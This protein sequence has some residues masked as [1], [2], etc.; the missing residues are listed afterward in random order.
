M[1]WQVPFVDYPSQYFAMETEITD[2]I[3]TVLSRGD[4]MLR[5]QLRD[6]EQNLA[7]FVGTRYSIGTST[8]TDAIHLSLR[9]ANIGDGDEVIT[10]AHT[11]VATGAAIHHTGATPVLVD[12]DDDHNINIDRVRDAITTKTRAI[13]P[14]H[15]NG[16]LC[17]MP[18][19]MA[20]AEKHHLVVIEDSAQALGGSFHGTRGGA[21]GLAGCFSFYPAKMLGAY[22][23][24]GAVTT[25][26]LTFATKLRSLRDH[27]RL[28]SGDIAGW[29]FN[30]RLDNLQA[31]IL[32]LKLR[33]LPAWIERRRELAS[34]YHEHLST[35]KELRLP[36]PPTT[37]GPHFDVFQNY[38][39]EAER[40][41]DLVAYLQNHGIELLI[42]WGGKALNHFTALGLDHYSVPRTDT[43]FRTLLLLP[44]HT[45]LTDDQILYVCATIEQFYD[46]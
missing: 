19:L 33:R 30:C 29:S 5:Q 40:R 26:D 37:Q 44:L 16:R 15:L 22:G 21:F 18:D 41:D 45:E 24:G 32:D 4:L 46:Q 38:E 34:L 43:I 8:C 12:I 6:F 20:I 17:N 9:A 7:D 14:V 36:P 2:T 31:A 13:V 35:M 10:T 42:P 28:P 3:R 39:I 25:N 23:D 11:F 1:S 27:G